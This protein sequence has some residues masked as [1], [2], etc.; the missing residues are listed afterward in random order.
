MDH[1]AAGRLVMVVIRRAHQNHYSRDHPITGNGTAESSL[2]MPLLLG[3]VRARSLTQEGG[4][5][6]RW[7]YYVPFCTWK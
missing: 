4:D 5:I 2:G 6:V 1:L 3:P 7:N